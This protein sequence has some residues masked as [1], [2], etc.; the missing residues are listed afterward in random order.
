MLKFTILLLP[1]ILGACAQLPEIK[2]G[3]VERADAA[4]SGWLLPLL[5]KTES[6]RLLMCDVDMPGQDCNADRTGLNAAGIG[7]IFLPL[8]V[9]IPVITIRASRAHIHVAINGIDATCTTGSVTL[10][11]N[12]T[13]LKISR[14]FCNWIVVGN[15]ISSV[16]LSIDWAN[17]ANGSFGGRYAIRFN[18]TG[19]GSGSGV[20]SAKVYL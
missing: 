10:E 16:K 8:K 17:R 19:N 20:Y 4:V 2:P 5:S 14:V 11:P 13:F 6:T 18:G 12:N 7:G 1:A 9:S 15:V 3:T